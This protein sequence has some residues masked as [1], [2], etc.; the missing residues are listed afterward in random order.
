MTYTK[1]KQALKKIAGGAEFCTH[2]H[3]K[4]CIGCGN[5]TAVN[6]T[7]GLD[8]ICFKRTKRYDIDE[9]AARIYEYTERR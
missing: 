9:V 2:G 1:I 5:S 7:R 4:Q 8:Y 6:I 3:I